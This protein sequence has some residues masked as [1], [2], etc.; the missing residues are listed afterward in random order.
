M[1]DLLPESIDVTW[2][3]LLAA[4]VFLAVFVGIVFLVYSRR[5]KAI[6]NEVELL[7]LQDD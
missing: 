5:R 2:G 7:P 1:R 6:Y 3:V 4:P